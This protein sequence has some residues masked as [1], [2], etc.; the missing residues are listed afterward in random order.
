MAKEQMIKTFK[1]GNKIYV[2]IENPTKDVESQIASLFGGIA[3]N[4]ATILAP[5]TESNTKEEAKNID[6]IAGKSVTE[7]ISATKVEEQ[8]TAASVETEVVSESAPEES[9]E[10]V[11]ESDDIT[12]SAQVAKADEQKTTEEPKQA[13]DTKPARP[14]L[15]EVKT[16]QQ[17]KELIRMAL[18]AELERGDHFSRKYALYVMFSNNEKMKNMISAMSE[19][20]AA[21]QWDARNMQQTAIDFC[22]YQPKTQKK[23]LE[24]V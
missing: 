24:W 16:L 20:E 19:E 11:C 2:V 10:S 3:G 15:P 18:V 12:E 17:A 1:E 7:P 9:K 22:G 6:A 5:Q 13:E 21:K 23:A 4:L 14:N 8:A